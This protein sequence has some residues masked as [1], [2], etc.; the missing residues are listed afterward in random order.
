MRA[1]MAPTLHV[2]TW[3]CCL[4]IA[5]QGSCDRV[6]R[7]LAAPKSHPRGAACAERNNCFC[8]LQR[9]PSKPTHKWM[10]RGGAHLRVFSDAA[11]KEETD[12]GHCFRGALFVRDPRSKRTNLALQGRITVVRIIGYSIK[13]QIHFTR[14]TFTAKLMSAKDAVDH[15]LL[16]SQVHHE[17]RQGPMAASEERQKRNQGAIRDPPLSCVRRCDVGLC[18]CVSRI[19]YGPNEQVPPVARSI[20]VH[21]WINEG[22]R[23]SHW[24]IYGM[25]HRID[26]PHVHFTC[27]DHG[28]HGR[29]PQVRV[30][31]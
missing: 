31:E 18:G 7:H 17:V 19:C 28:T 26:A 21:C 22:Y 16:L 20:V 5:Y 8:W 11:F 29:L 3:S 12:S 4:L 6:H 24:W 30:C 23:P 13:R 25:Q 9:K 14:N 10:P 1:G 15:G 27:C 2:P